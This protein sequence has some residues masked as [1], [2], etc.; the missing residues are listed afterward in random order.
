M[1]GE[2]ERIIGQLRTIPSLTDTDDDRLSR[3]AALVRPKTAPAGAVIFSRDDRGDAL[4][5]LVKGRAKT[6]LVS[7][8]GRELALSYMEAPTQFGSTGT[9]EGT[10]RAADVVAITD[11]ELLLLDIADLERAFA[12]DPGLAIEMIST[13]SLRLRQ[14]LDT[15]QELAFSDASHRVMRVMLNVATAA[16]ETIGAP[17]ISGMTHYE[18]ATLAGTS[19]ETASRTISALARDG[20]VLTR[21]RKIFV[22]LYKLTARLG[23]D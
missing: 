17:V 4:Y 15:M 7:S 6:A 20:V 9:A 13:L 1:A 8:D 2:R 12:A 5:L 19:R 21:G 23:E 10:T 22:D 16:Y 11:V 18:I 3:L 14:A